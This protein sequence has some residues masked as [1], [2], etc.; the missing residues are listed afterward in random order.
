MIKIRLSGAALALFLLVSCTSGPVEI[1]DNPSPAELIQRAQEASDKNRYNQ[2][3]Q[4]YQAILDRFPSNIDAV[5][6]AE[7]EIAF[8]H[9][10][11]KK[12]EDAKAELN[13]LLARYDSPDEE[14]LPQQFKRLAHIVLDRIEEIEQKN[15]LKKDSAE[16]DQL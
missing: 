14:L 5:C 6:A 3:L 15:L 2:S 13:A 9:H 11:Q 12:Y 8:I 7:Y 1:N 10:K 4:Y 16:I